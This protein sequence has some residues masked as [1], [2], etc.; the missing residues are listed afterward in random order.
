ME[1]NEDGQGNGKIKTYRKEKRREVERGWKKKVPE[2][3]ND[4]D[5]FPIRVIR[6]G[7][8]LL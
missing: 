1:R 7:G 8:W 6:K 5:K 2:K 3:V 4:I